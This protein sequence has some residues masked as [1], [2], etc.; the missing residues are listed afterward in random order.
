LLRYLPF[1]LKIQIL[2]T[3]KGGEAILEKIK[4][5]NYDVLNKRPTLTKI[6]FA[7]IA[8]AALIKGK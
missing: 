1:M 2:F 4:K 7:K 6:D 3:I 5:N 8:L